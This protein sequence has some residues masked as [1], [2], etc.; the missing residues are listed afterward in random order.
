MNGQDSPS[1]PIPREVISTAHAAA[2]VLISNERLGG[3]SASRHRL[4]GSRVEPLNP[5]AP[6]S[7]RGRTVPRPVEGT[8]PYL[9]GLDGIRAIAVLAVIA[10][11]LNFGWASGGLLGVQVF[12]VLS[13]YLITD[14]L[15]AEYGRHQRDRV[16]AV[17]D[18][19]G[20]TAPAGPLRDAVRDRRMGHA[21]RPGPTGRPAQR[22][23]GRDLLRQQL[24]VHL[25]P[26]L[27]LRQVRP[28][29]AARAPL[30]AGHRGAV[31]PGLAAPGA[32]RFPVDPHQ[33]G[34]DPGHPGR[35]RRLGAGDGRPLLAP[36]P[37]PP[38]STTAPTPGPS[39]C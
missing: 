22:P 30:V 16:E 4:V 32:G 27:L 28:A 9:P 6:L 13:G 31:L 2:A 21:V 8:S 7:R 35:G 23:A 17:L 18:P 39:P 38:G 25:P 10:Y 5:V 19:A 14:L 1:A 33:A 34:P 20:P 26:R 11:H 36:A 37:I 29:V 15:V 3:A 12:F 24:V